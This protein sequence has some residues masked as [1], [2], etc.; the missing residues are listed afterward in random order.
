MCAA[1]R[2]CV[3]AGAAGAGAGA[4]AIAAVHCCR[5]CRMFPAIQNVVKQSVALVLCEGHS[6][7]YLFY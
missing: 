2:M 4:A 1:A 7:T 6:A 3:Y 5:I